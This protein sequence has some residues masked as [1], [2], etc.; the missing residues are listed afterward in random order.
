MGN[1]GVEIRGITIQEWVY[2][3]NFVRQRCPFE[4]V[5][6]SDSRW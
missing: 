3:D 2:H 1:L 6:I 5:E 4:G